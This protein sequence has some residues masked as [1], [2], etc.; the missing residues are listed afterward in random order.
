MSNTRAR[1]LREE[2]A[3]LF[4]Q[5][6]AELEETRASE[7]GDFA[8]PDDRANW[9]KKMDRVDAL[10]RQ[11]KDIEADYARMNA[12][13]DATEARQELLND[14]KPFGSEGRD[15][16]DEGA[17]Y[18]TQFR[19]WMLGTVSETELR[20]H[21]H[22]HTVEALMHRAGMAE[23]RAIQ[24]QVKG[25]A[26]QGGHLVPTELEAQV[27]ATLKE[28]GGMR[29]VARIVNTPSGANLDWPISDDTGNLAKIIAEAT[30]PTTTTRVPFGKVTLEAAKYQSGPIKISREL[31]QDSVIDIEAFVAEAMGVRFGRATNA[32]YT[33]RSST[34]TTGPHGITNDSTGA[35]NVA[36]NTLS[37]EELLSL[38]HSVDPA[39]RRG[40]SVAWMTAD[41]GVNEIRK[42]RWGSSR[43]A[44]WSPSIAAGMPDTLMGYP[45]VINQDV[46][47]EGTSGNKWLWFGN[48][49][50]YFIRDVAGID[51]LRLEERYAEEGNIA[52]LGFMRTDG[53]RVTGSTV[54]ARR[55]YRAI[56]QS[57]A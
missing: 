47:L 39:Y 18:R 11:A 35:V 27:Q 36:N 10:E 30:A 57:T 48:W 7:S 29:Q 43:Q 19:G 20:Q 21:P 49:S 42:V 34:E 44:V 53:R 33:T 8:T 32:H 41:D 54:I 2:R 4:M 15:A 46:P 16:E 9:R 55:P 28:Y 51:M 37:Y 45:V 23:A 25:T 40:N 24:G 14:T 12:A 3:K 13:Q 50:H 38:Y 6:R 31:L 17:D 1:E 56:I 5:A 22:L 52:L 26:A